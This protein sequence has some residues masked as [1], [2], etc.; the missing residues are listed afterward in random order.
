MYVPALADSR[1]GESGHRAYQH[2]Q[3]IREGIYSVEVDRF[4]H[5]VIY[6]SIRCL[7]L[8]RGDLW[9]RFNTGDNLLFRDADFCC[10][11]KSELFRTLSGIGNADAEALVGRLILACR[12][13]LEGAPLLQ[14]IIGPNGKVLPLSA[15]E[16][17]RSRG[18]D[19]RGR[20]CRERG[21]VAACGSRRSCRGAGEHKPCMAIR[22]G[23]GCGVEGEGRSRGTKESRRRGCTV[24][25]GSRSRGTEESGRRGSAIEGGRLKPRHGRKRKKRQCD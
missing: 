16:T 7:M 11:A 23:G 25:G 22:Y 15:I 10:P 14:D 1:S 4:S 19:V 21:A 12:R 20:C 17:R 9:Q 2:P 24:E 18:R 8:G 13:P 5:L 3:R 6:T